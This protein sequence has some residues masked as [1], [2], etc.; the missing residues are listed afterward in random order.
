MTYNKKALQQYQSVNVH[1]A[2]EQA[3]PHKLI[4]LLFEGL[5][6]A[7]TRAKGL[8]EQKDFTGKSE[9]INKATDIVIHLQASL[10]HDQGGEIASNLDS[11]YS[12]VLRRIMDGNRNNDV[13]ALEEVIRLVNEVKSGWDEMPTENR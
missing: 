1:S 4:S 12:Y 8:I 10:D 3:S 6:T 13:A 11:L 7:L 5:L 2:V 9:Q